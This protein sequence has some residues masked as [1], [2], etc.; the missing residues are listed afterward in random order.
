MIHTFLMGSTSSITEQS[1]VNIVRRTPAVGAKNVVFL[2]LPVALPQSGKLRVLNLLTYRKSAFSPHRGESFTDSSEIWHG[3]ADRRSG[4]SYK[5]SRQPVHGVGTRTV[6][7]TNYHQQL[8]S[9]IMHRFGR[10]FCRL[11][12]D[13]MY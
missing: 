6:H 1:L 3:R 10:Y 2:F 8:A 11:L 9:P 4:W 13:H 12:K 5:L 7:V